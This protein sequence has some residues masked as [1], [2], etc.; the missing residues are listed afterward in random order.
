MNEPA[1]TNPGVSDTPVIVLN[2]ERWDD[3]LECLR[4]LQE[5]GDVTTVWL[6]DNGSAVDRSEEARSICPALRVLQLQQNYGFAGGMNRA[7]RI[8]AAEGHTFAYLLNNDSTVDPGFL[9]AALEA[10]A[11]PD[12]AIVGSRI[13]GYGSLSG[14][15][16]FDGEYC[17]PH[18]R[19]VDHRWFGTRQVLHVNGAGMLV[20]LAALERHGYFDERYFC[21]HE[22]VELCWRLT[23]AGWSMVV[24]GQS[25]VLHK[26]EG[27]DDSSN[28]I[29]Y[30]VRNRFLL[31]EHLHGWKGLKR[32]LTAL[33]HAAAF[34]R[35]ALRLR[36]GHDWWAVAAGVYDGSIGR[37]G[38]RKPCTNRTVASL[39]LLVLCTLLPSVGGL[40]RWRASR[41]ARTT[42][43]GKMESA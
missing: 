16:V 33:R 14:L 9:R 5:S 7:L 10:A 22:E 36:R 11:T 28:A 29:Y 12:V 2:W 20:R 23:K 30:R 32:R 31:F 41:R 24:A 25:V 15:T 6:V 42:V 1:A 34:G 4:S 40:R 21:Y 26:R 13:T 39:Q 35:R 27:S 8:A 37:F 17:R 18:D 19:P 43:V 3:T 38:K